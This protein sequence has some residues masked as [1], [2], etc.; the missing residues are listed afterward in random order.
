MRV[1]PLER[2]N[3]WN[4]F[5]KFHLI[6]IRLFCAI[7]TR[8]LLVCVRGHIPIL[9]TSIY[10]FFIYTNIRL[11]QTICITHARSLVI[12]QTNFALGYYIFICLY[13]HTHKHIVHDPAFIQGRTVLEAVGA[14]L[15]LNITQHFF[16][17]FEYFLI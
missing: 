12:A 4:C 15:P 1:F 13:T 11:N 2:A 14:L 10:L 8:Q 7:A 6:W 9:C 17:I 3:S 5:E 16:L